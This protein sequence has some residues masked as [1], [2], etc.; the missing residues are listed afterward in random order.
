MLAKLLTIFLFLFSSSLYSAEKNFISDC[1][2]LKKSYS[3]IKE[4]IKNSICK[5]FKSFYLTYDEN[6]AEIYSDKLYL[7]DKEFGIW[8]P[9][10]K[11]IHHQYYI[12]EN[13]PIYDVTYTLDEYGKRKTPTNYNTNTTL[14]SVRDSF[15]VLLGGSFTFGT[16]VN[17][18]QT[19][20]AYINK[21]SDKY[22]A[23]NF[24]VGG[25]ALHHNLGLINSNKFKKQISQ[26]KGVGFYLFIDDHVNRIAGRGFWSTVFTNLPYYHINE[27]H[28]VL[29]ETFQKGRPLTTWIQSFLY[30]VFNTNFSK[31]TKEN[32]IKLTCKLVVK[33]QKDF[34]K[35]Y[36]ESQFYFL[37]HNFLV[38]E[39]KTY[40][41]REL[42]KCLLQN[43]INIVNL[44][45]PNGFKQE[46]WFFE[47]NHPKPITNRYIAQYLL[48]LLNR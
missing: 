15:V 27:G 21:E 41:Q 30:K 44:K 28:L 11:V 35:Q 39:S 6:K 40:I 31:I 8:H 5:S 9:A 24:G 10:N 43:N 1:K 48:K 42:L 13:Q 25:T 4:E 32:D 16:G 37:F 19:I 34:K 14:T 46:E 7:N 45:R 26:E 2:T 18:S 17:D 33:T 47:D 3:N 23:Y 22:N 36:N 20:A 12:R 38:S 29:E